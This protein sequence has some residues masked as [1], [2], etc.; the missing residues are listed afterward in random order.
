[1]H[2][3]VRDPTRDVFAFAEDAGHERFMQPLIQRLSAEYAIGVSVTL[4]SARGGHG[5]VL[6]ELEQ[7][8]RDLRRSRDSLPDLIIVATDGNCKGYPHRRQELDSVAGGLG[9]FVVYAI[10]DPHI[11][12]WLLLDSAAFK[13]VLG[14]G[15]DAPDQKCERDRYKALLRQAVRATGVAPLLGG[16]EYAEDLVRAMD[17]ER[18]ERADPSLG[19]LLSG[20]REKFAGWRE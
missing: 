14:R 16:L 5:K 8:I 13:E 4:C 15:C 12:R 19:R 18:V 1:M 17:L 20:L 6:S 7:F 2:D 9:E 11:E 3:P 10:P